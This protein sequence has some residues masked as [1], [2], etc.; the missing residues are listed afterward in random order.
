MPITPYIYLTYFNNFYS[1]VVMM[2]KAQSKV[3]SSEVAVSHKPIQKP[4]QNPRK[5]EQAEVEL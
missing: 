4:S 5:S 2:H 3:A 1:A